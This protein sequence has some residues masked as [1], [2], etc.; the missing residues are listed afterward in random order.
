[1]TGRLS[2]TDWT[3]GALELLR[4]DG[5]AALAINRLCEHLGVTRGSFYWHFADLGAL[6]EAVTERWCADTRA[7]LDSFA[8]IDRLPPVE[9]LRAMTL[10]LL[11]DGS[12]SVERALRAWAR[13]D[14]RV[15]GVVAEADLAVFGSVQGA[16]VDLGRGPEEARVLAG[17]LVYAGIGF[18]HGEAGLPRPTVAE[19]DRLL[20]LIV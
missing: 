19:V 12:A 14:E 7:A 9:R 16:L 10:R 2:A 8:S 15:A 1:M 13:T 6:K 11:D 18:A 17:L 3:D 20:G 5:V 4:T